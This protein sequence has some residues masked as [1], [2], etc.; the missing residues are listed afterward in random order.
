MKRSYT[1]GI[2]ALTRS[3]LMAIEHFS[4]IKSP[5]KGRVEPIGAEIFKICFDYFSTPF[6]WKLIW[7]ERNY[8]SELKW[9]SRLMR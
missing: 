8:S 2:P 1:R 9:N 7:L 4:F 6:L 3:V 5:M